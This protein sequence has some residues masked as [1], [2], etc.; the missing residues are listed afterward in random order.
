M[1]IRAKKEERMPK[2]LIIA[3]AGVNHNGSLKTAMEMVEAAANAGADVIKFQTFQAQSLVSRFAPKAVYQKKATGRNGSQFEMIKNLELDFNAHVKLIKHCQAR[4][5]SFLSSPFDLESIDVL[6]RLGLR[7]FKIPSGEITDLPY[8]RTIGS[9]RRKIIMSTG[10]A[11][12]AEVRVALKVLVKSGTKKE[13]II[14]LHCN[15]EYP[16]PF[17]DVNLRAMVTMKNMLGV[18]VGYS[19]HTLGTDVAAAAVALGAKV[20]EKHFTLDKTMPGPDH[21]ASLEPDELKRMVSA[22]RNVEIALGS[23]DKKVSPS[24]KVNISAARKSIVARVTIKKGDRFTEDNLAVKRP[25]TGISP[26]FCDDVLG[27]AAKKDFYQ[28]ELITI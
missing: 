13:D 23:G 3:E 1:V 16:T 25:G 8:L 10:M 22:V 2:V 26:M 9:L 21:Q 17:K 4:R 11:T 27:A 24:E 14:I 12:L 19:D 20:I 7:M 15:T 5:I 6:A 28:D 18:Q